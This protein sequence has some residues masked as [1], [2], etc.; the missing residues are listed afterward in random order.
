MSGFLRSYALRRLAA[1]L[2]ASL[3]ALAF[4]G[5]AQAV[6]TVDLGDAEAYSVLAGFSVTSTG[7]TAMSES[8]GVSP[9][10]TLAGTPIVLG[11]THL[12]D[13]DAAAA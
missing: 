5:P 10:L 8:M 7:P 3:A 13:A 11:E 1:C 12:A 9:E 4:A 2:C 6:D